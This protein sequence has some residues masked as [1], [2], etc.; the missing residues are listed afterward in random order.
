MEQYDTIDFSKEISRVGLSLRDHS[1]LVGIA[2]SVD[3]QC[4]DLG[5]EDGP[6]NPKWNSVK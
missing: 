4:T 1:H 3:I 6:L 2:F 5:K